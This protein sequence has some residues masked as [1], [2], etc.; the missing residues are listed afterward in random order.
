MKTMLAVKTVLHTALLALL[1][2]MPWSAAQ[3]VE[4]NQLDEDTQRVLEPFEN[5]WDKLPQDRQDKLLQ[6]AERWKLLPDSKLAQIHHKIER[7]KSL[8]PEERKRLRKK[9][10]WFHKLPPERRRELREQWRNM[11]AEERRHFRQNY[12]KDRKK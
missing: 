3:A 4:W 7:F 11:T 2:A 12:I 8:P 5:G 6:R 9:Q 10:Q 1:L